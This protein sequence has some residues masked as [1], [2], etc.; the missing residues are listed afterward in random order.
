MAQK[1]WLRYAA[2]V[3][4]TSLA[5]TACSSSDGVDE[6]QLA[7]TDCDPPQAQASGNPS[8]DPL[9]FGGLLPQT[10]DLAFLGPPEIAATELA[11]KEINEAGGVLG[12]PVSINQG[13]SGDTTTN[14]AN[15]T[16]DRLL[17]DG[18][19]VIIGAASSGV[20]LNVIDKIV[21]AGV[22][23]FSPANTSDQFVCYPDKGLY[24]RTA[25]TD[26]LQSQALVQMMASDGVQRV[27]VL[28]RNDPYGAGLARNTERFLQEAGVGSDQIELI[29]YDPN[30]QSFNAE[31]DRIAQFDPDAIAVIGFDESKRIITRM[32]EIGI[33]PQDKLVY[34]T[35]GNMGNALG[36]GLAPGLLEGMKGTAPQTALSSDFE[37]RVR[38][39][40]AEIGLNLSDLQY[41]AE[42]Y[43]AAI[44]TALAA[45]A[46]GSTR[47]VDI[48]S[49]IN[50][51]TRD[52]EDCT[53]FAECRDL[54]AA[55]QDI[56]FNGITGELEFAPA[57]EPGIG[58]YGVLEFGP[59]NALLPVE[60]YIVVSID[61]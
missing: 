7:D 9:K 1:K 19:Q 31:L 38:A 59:D 23:M 43:D 28:A 57:G 13:D 17:A 35:D 32:A 56:N 30:A 8:T 52:G 25:P 22:V 5:L 58:S 10:G 41:S 55:G 2:M 50:G 18:V 4:A 27:A 34:G 6:V 44:I 11:V 37:E 49:E 36:E 14:I 20:S 45:E 29:I 12:N 48:A 3:G 53:T 61:D 16:V 60:D 24:F 47:G 42:A 51:V 26:V 39:T 15:Q 40:G 54:I 21:D 46:A 33:G